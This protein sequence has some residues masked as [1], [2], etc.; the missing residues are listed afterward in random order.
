MN[1]QITR[2]ALIE[3]YQRMGKDIRNAS[4]QEMRSLVCAQCHVEYYFK[5]DGK[6]LAF[7]WDKGLTADAAL[8]YYDSIGFSDWTNPLSKAPM[9]KAQHPDYEISQTGIHAQRGVSCADCHMPYISEGGQKFTDH[10]IE[11]PLNKISTSCQVCH[12]QSEAEHTKNVYERQD[13]IIQ[14][15]DKLEESLVMAHLEAKKA[16]ESGAGDD[17]MKPSLQLIRKA[18]WF[19]DYAAA[20]HGASFH[21]PLEVARINGLGIDYAQQAR[22]SLTRILAQHGIT[23]PIA[24]PDLSSK[25]KSQRFIGLDMPKLK[26]EKE[27][28]LSKVVPIWD[29]V[30]IRD[31]QKGY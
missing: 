26:Q 16:W 18:Q 17:E 9:L 22:I 25:D 23:K 11:S 27:Q 15:R 6:Y 3:A 13:K 19:W 14:L 1:L 20:S 28:F 24:Y 12:R 29:S 10:H 21:S 30:S 8:A 5:G 31:N 4:Q 2:P 7:P